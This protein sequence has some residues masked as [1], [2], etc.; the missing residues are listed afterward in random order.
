MSSSDP[1]VTEIDQGMS[2]ALN[3]VS[4]RLV[5]ALDNPDTVS[6]IALKDMLCKAVKLYAKKADMGLAT[7][8]PAGGGDLIVNDVMITATDMLHALNVQLFELSMW[9][10]MTGNT[11]APQHRSAAE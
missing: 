6:D 9:Q 2:G 1:I 11:V 3:D 7:P 5:A 10:A 8:F 4:A